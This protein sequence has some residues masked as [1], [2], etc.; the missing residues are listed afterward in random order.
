MVRMNPYFWVY[1][2][3]PT[4]QVS[5]PFVMDRRKYRCVFCLKTQARPK[6]FAKHL[7]GHAGT[8]FRRCNR[9][10]TRKLPQYAPEFDN[11]VRHGCLSKGLPF[12]VEDFIPSREAIEQAL[13]DVWG[14]LPKHLPGAPRS[15]RSEDEE[16]RRREEAE[17]EDQEEAAEGPRWVL[18]GSPEY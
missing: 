17:A 4:A 7:L 9:C 14:V 12:A 2:L 8:L 18:S 13:T 16:E 15:P 3:G 11:P 6:A 5:F 1:S 10:G